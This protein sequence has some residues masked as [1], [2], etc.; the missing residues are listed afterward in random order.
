MNQ[1][2]ALNLLL[3]TTDKKQSYDYKSQVCRLFIKILI[4]LFKEAEKE[5]FEIY[6]QLNNVFWFSFA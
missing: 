1:A 3:T 2:H 4:K 6:Y 5:A